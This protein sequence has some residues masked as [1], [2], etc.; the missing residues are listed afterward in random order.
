MTK[1]KIIKKYA[2]RIDILCCNHRGKR[3]LDYQIGYIK[4]KRCVVAICKDCE[5]RQILCS[6]FSKK[7]LMRLLKKGVRGVNI[8][9][10]ISLHDIFDIR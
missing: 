1:S 2:H 6:G 8:I 10:T 7:I 5:K 9:A 3:D 4:Y